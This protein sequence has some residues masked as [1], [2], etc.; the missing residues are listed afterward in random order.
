MVGFSGEVSLLVSVAVVGVTTPISNDVLT[1]FDKSGSFG[2]VILAVKVY[3]PE[4]LEKSK[5]DVVD[6][7]FGIKSSGYV[8][9][10][11]APAPM[12]C[13]ASARIV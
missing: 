11:L 12:L 2:I 5:V 4:G 9:T 13:A 3:G 10:I 6:P 1:L 8:S 7:T